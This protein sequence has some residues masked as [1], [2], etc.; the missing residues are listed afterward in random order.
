[1]GF[2][3]AIQLCDLLRKRHIE[4]FTETL[5]WM[6]RSDSLLNSVSLNCEVINVLE[7]DLLEVHRLEKEKYP[8]KEVL[9]FRHGLIE[10]LA[11]GLQITYHASP[12][13]FLRS[14][15]QQDAIRHS[16]RW[17][18]ALP[19]AHPPED[20]CLVR[21]AFVT[22]QRNTWRVS[23]AT[24]SQLRKDV[25]QLEDIWIEN[26]DEE[27]NGTISYSLEFTPTIPIGI[28]F[29]LL[30]NLSESA[31]GFTQKSKNTHASLLS[32][33]TNQPKSIFK[34][35]TEREYSVG[36]MD[37]HMKFV[38]SGEE[39]K[40]IR[41]CKIPFIHPKNLIQILNPIRQQV[42]FN[43]LITSCAKPIAPSDSIPPVVF[44]VLFEAPYWVSLLFLPDGLTDF[45]SVKVLV[46]EKGLVSAEIS[47]PL[48]RFSDYVTELVQTS[49][50]IP[51]TMYNFLKVIKEENS[52]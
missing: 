39:T 16:H 32:L 8:I 3:D 38:F 49:H 24:E 46:A 28:H 6:M 21:R 50:N 41:L 27:G 33:L 7:K 45:V 43:E 35:Q 20:D 5:R 29:R 25:E 44:E 51:L 23:L 13:Y 15:E 48:E 2:Y 31:P 26:D 17:L 40:A 30:R 18:T 10:R 19:Q 9:L 34:P 22:L 52:K 4:E 36:F 1:L 37:S 12:F 14:Q 42:V 11:E 47:P